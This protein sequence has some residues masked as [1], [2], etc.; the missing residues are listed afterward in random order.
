MRG[1]RGLGQSLEGEAGFAVVE[2][3]SGVEQI[4]EPRNQGR[5]REGMLVKG[6]ELLTSL[7]NSRPGFRRS[8][9][10]VEGAEALVRGTFMLRVPTWPCE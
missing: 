2:R 5:K 8:W 4:G 10:R 6:Q 9:R 7:L 3:W 1:L